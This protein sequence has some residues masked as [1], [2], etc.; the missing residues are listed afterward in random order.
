MFLGQQKCSLNQI[1]NFYHSNR[2]PCKKLFMNN[3]S[4][5]DVNFYQHNNSNVETI[6]F[7]MTEVKSCL[8]SFNPNS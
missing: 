1:S 7:F 6:F 5:P 2:F 4:E 8:T 3:E